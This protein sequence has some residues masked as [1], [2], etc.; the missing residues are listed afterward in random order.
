MSLAEARKPGIRQKRWNARASAEEEKKKPKKKTQWELAPY[1][2]GHA[3]ASCK[4]ARQNPSAPYVTKQFGAAKICSL[5]FHHP[6]QPAA[7]HNPFA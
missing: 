6:I 5:C 2:Y 7:P 1:R 3:C 4:G